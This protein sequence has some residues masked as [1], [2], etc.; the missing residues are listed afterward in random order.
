MSRTS[1]T[2]RHFLGGSLA[3]AFLAGCGDSADGGDADSAT[4]AGTGDKSSTPAPASWTVTHDHGTVE[5]PAEPTRV[6]AMENRR[7]LE[8]A[9]VLGLPLVGVGAYGGGADVAAPFVPVGDATFE[10]LNTSEPNYEQIAA[11]RPDLIL[12][13]ELYLQDEFLDG[14]LGQAAPILPVASSGPWRPDLERVA[15]WL[16]REATLTSA[17]DQYDAELARV[18]TT[19]EK[20]LAD[21][22]VAIVEYFPS[23]RT[24]Y[25][26]GLDGFQL[27]A[28]TLD[29]LGGRLV[30]LQA[31]RDYFDEPFSLENVGD[32]VDAA[33][34]LLVLPSEEAGDELDGLE[35]WQRL[36]AVE[37][38]RVVRTDTRTNQGSVFAATA[39]VALLDELY[40][41]I[42]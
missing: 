19:H 41:T 18:R 16:R 34:I 35:L 1:T 42:A 28:N 6:I 17:L 15:G 7:D 24:F 25:A 30:D 29:S 8:T 38:G 26:G 20:R 2:R 22:P 10:V 13:R 32:L 3:A 5:V 39:C 36:P 31:E 21:S 23:D 12:S 4:G 14:R 37:A 33:A 27:Q 11:L 9:V 40:G